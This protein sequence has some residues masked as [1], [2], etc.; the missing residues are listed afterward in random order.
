[1]SIIKYYYFYC[2]TVL[3]PVIVSVCAEMI[4]NEKIKGIVSGAMT[5]LFILIV[6]AWCVIAIINYG[7]ING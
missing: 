4:P 7:A 2:I 1:M 3:I 6:L 5:L